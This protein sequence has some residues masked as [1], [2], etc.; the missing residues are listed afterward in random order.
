MRGGVIDIW[1]I[2]VCKFI[3]PMNECKNY[4]KRLSEEA[5]YRLLE[6]EPQLSQRKIAEHL[7]V[8]LGKVNYCMCAPALNVTKI[9][10]ALGLITSK[11]S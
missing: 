4:D 1:S 3:C 5:P 11:L 6:Q 8:S 2:M 9:R 10:K 7:G